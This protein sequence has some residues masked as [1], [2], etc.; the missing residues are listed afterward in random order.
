MLSPSYRGTSCLNMLGPSVRV[1]S[2][3]PLSEY[4]L[5]DI[6]TLITSTWLSTVATINCVEALKL[7][8]D[9]I[10]SPLNVTYTP[11]GRARKTLISKVKVLPSSII[12]SEPSL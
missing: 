2:M 8:C 10:S 5:K 12:W 3:P 6:E 4:P 7:N 9:E 1:Y 11:S